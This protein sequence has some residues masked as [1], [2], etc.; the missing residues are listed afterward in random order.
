VTASTAQRGSMEL[1]RTASEG[2]AI[3]AVFGLVGEYFTFAAAVGFAIFLG[4]TRVP[5][6]LVDRAFGLQLRER[7]IDLIARIS[8]G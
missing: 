6:R 1:Y 7:F 8:P 4:V 3:G 5:L 2:R